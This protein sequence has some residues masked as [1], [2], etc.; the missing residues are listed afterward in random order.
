MPRSSRLFSSHSQGVHEGSDGCRTQGDT[1]MLNLFFSSLTAQPHSSVLRNILAL[2][3]KEI[4][5]K[6]QLWLQ[7]H[8]K[9]QTSHAL[10]TVYIGVRRE[11]TLNIIT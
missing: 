7:S 5:S 6:K 9:G 4:A 1:V 3:A 11:E 2:S 8:R 10:C